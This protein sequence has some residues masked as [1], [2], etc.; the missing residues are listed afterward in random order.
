MEAGNQ[1]YLRGHNT[2]KVREMASITKM[3]TLYGCLELN[4]ELKIN[5]VTSVVRIYETG[6]TGTLAHLAAG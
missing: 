3:Y 6:M 1:T 5:P 2:S 4:K